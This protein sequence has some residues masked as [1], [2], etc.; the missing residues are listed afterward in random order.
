MEANLG[1]GFWQEMVDLYGRGDVA[2]TYLDLQERFGTDI[3]SSLFLRLLDRH[4]ILLAESERREAQTA[5]AA[6]HAHVVVP[7]RTVRWW[8]RPLAR[9][10]TVATYR[11]RIKAAEFM[12]EHM[13][14]DMLV[15]WLSGRKLASKP[16]RGVLGRCPPSRVL[17]LAACCRSRLA[18]R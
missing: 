9:T 5:V 4:V 15:Q 17:S 8:M 12:A 1:D 3:V 11:N 7:L 18:L 14:L 10:S 13:E 6:W 2:D 16:C